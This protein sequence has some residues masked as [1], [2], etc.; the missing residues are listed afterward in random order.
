M[1]P[2]LL[3]VAESEICTEYIYL[4]AVQFVAIC[5]FRFPKD[6]RMMPYDAALCDGNSSEQHD[7]WA[8]ECHCVLIVSETL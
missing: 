6:C 3:M 7:Q 5:I 1:A 2:L 8:D 4:M